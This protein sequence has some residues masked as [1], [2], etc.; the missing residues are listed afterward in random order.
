MDIDWLGLSDNE[1]EA[2]DVAV[3]AEITRRARLAAENQIRDDGLSATRPDIPGAPWRQPTGA[4]DAYPTGWETTHD[5][6]LWRSR[7]PANV[8]VP[9][10]D[11]RWWEDL[12]PAPDGGGD[13]PVE[14]SEWAP[15]RAYATH[16]LVTHDGALWRCV[17]PHTSMVGW[18]PGIAPSLWTKEKHA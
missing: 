18:E 4:H 5:G 2:L 14:V 8:T 9:G 12:G 10:A 15:N 7:I 3:R 17:I 13:P 16:D 1:L 6:H 11:A